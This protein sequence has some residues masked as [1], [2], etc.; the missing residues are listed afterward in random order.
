MSR[1]RKDDFHW[2]YLPLIVFMAMPIIKLY[3]EFWFKP[4]IQFA[5]RIHWRYLA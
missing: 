5:A 3:M 4:I 1:K 2:W